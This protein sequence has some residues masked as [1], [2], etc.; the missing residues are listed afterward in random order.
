MPDIDGSIKDM[1]GEKI[2]FVDTFVSLCISI[3]KH[4]NILTI[5]TYK[6]KRHFFQHE[7]RTAPKFGTHVRI[8]TRL[9]LTKKKLTHPTPGGF[10]GLSI[11]VCGMC[12]DVCLFVGVWVSATP[13]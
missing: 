11:Y 2:E 12:D 6:C 13:H 1:H 4:V 9:A 5:S 7:R 10:R 8:E 3:S